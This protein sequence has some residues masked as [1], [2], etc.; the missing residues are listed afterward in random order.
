MLDDPMTSN[1]DT[2][3]YLMIGEIQK[4][5]SKINDGSYLIILTHNCHFY[6]N[7][8]PNMMPTYKK[9]GVEGL[10]KEIGFYEKYGVSTFSLTV[11]KQL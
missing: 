8:R 10:Y 4:L 3:Q 9:S 2:M 6:L 1:D 7:V 11:S 5:C